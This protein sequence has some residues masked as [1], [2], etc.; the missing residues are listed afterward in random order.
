MTV[1]TITTVG[2]NEMGKLSDEGRIFTIIL[3]FL[4]M[5]II[6]YIVGLVTQVMVELQI[7]TIIGR[8]KL[9]QQPRP[10]IVGIRR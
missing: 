1:I 4:G 6:L 2:F 5:G 3:I 9:N 8:K 7:S 10:L